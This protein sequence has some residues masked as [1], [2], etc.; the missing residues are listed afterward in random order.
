MENL[1]FVEHFVKDKAGWESSMGKRVE[2]MGAEDMTIDKAMKQ[3]EWGG[4]EVLF[5]VHNTEGTLTCCLWK[6]SSTMPL[7]E[8]QEFIDKFTG[9]FTTNKVYVVEGGLGLNLKKLD[10]RGY[11][12]DFINTA[13]GRNSPGF[14]D[15]SMLWMCH[16]H[17]TDASKWDGVS[18]RLIKTIN[19][20]CTTPSDCK[21]LFNPGCGSPLTLFFSG[22]SDAVCFEATPAG[23]KMEDLQKDVDEWTNGSAINTLYPINDGE[24]LNVMNLSLDHWCQDAF[25][26]AKQ[27]QEVTTKAVHAT[28]TSETIPIASQ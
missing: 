24:S 21:T 7:S 26:W 10:F 28:V 17:V 23:Y 4:H 14:L 13:Q 16:H 19:E 18:E 3:D 5:T 11:L 20:K 25:A 27:S 8:F 12:R 6:T 9:A 15:A 2:I 22:G 1:Y